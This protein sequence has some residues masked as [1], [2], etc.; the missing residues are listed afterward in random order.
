MTHATRPTQLYD[1]DTFEHRGYTFRVTFPRDEG[2][3]EPWKEHDG[4]GPV[5]EW[6][7]RE[8]RAGERLIASDRHHKR[9]YDFAE[10]CQIAKR[11]RWGTA[12]GRQPG[13][14]AK[15]YAARA[16]EADYQYC[17]GWCEDR[18][19]WV[20]VVVTLDHGG[21]TLQASLWGIESLSDPGYFVE[22][23]YELADE[24]LS[25]VEVES[26]DVQLSEN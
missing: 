15:A 26:P 23:A 8:K 25:R 24:I 2:M 18:W 9:F 10:A 7:A 17:K 3:S 19:T 1:E 14:T 6:T 13:E 5:S 12:D 11:D 20:G 22:E 21:D 4:H 16:V